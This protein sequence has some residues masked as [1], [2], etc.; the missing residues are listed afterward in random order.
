[1]KQ[2]LA[3]QHQKQD[4]TVDSQP[5][6]VSQST[7]RLYTRTVM[8]WRLCSRNVRSILGSGFLW[9]NSTEV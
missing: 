2:E 7:L 9:S 6:T 5:S 3:V 8:D 4:S 1:M